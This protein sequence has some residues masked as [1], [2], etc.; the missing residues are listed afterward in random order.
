M[1]NPYHDMHYDL[2]PTYY[3]E[4]IILSALKSFKIRVCNFF[5]AAQIAQDAQQMLFK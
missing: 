1:M 4:K 3:E 5:I 2:H